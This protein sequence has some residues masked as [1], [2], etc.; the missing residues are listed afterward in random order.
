MA[1]EPETVTP[2]KFQFVGNFLE[3]SG[4]WLM[5][6]V[7]GP[8]AD[9]LKRYGA[10]AVILLSLMAMYRIS[11]YV[12]GILANPF[13][14]EVGFTKTQVANIA[15]LYGCGSPCS[16]SAQAAGRSSNSACDAASFC[17]PY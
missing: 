7:V 13:Y 6:A 17:R 2:P 5:T 1:R 10:F 4:Q 8:F 16:A 11:D 9:F 14:L 12:L 3:Q 15:K